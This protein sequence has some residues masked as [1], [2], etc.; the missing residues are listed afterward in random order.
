[1][2]PKT[3]KEKPDAAVQKELKRMIIED[4]TK[5]VAFM[6]LQMGNMCVDAHAGTMTIKQESDIKKQRYE[7]SCKIKIKKVNPV[8]DSK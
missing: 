8:A 5:M 6:L 4:P 2:A 1:M 3:Q 7:I